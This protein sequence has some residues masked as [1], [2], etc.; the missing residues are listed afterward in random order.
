EQIAVRQRTMLRD[1]RQRRDADLVARALDRL[2]ETARGLGNLVE[3]LQQAVV[4]DA[5][6]GEMVER[7][8]TVFGRYR[9][10]DGFWKRGVGLHEA[11]GPLY[12]IGVAVRDL[13]QAEE[14]YRALGA[15]LHGRESVAGE[16]VEVSFVELGGVHIELLRPLD[17]EGSV[18]RFLRERGQGVHH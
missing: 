6:L 10:R 15:H 4:A 13:Q 3:A 9:P 1:L 12:H 11:L 2:E 5:T 17:D 8:T 14:A 7:L 18:A 16:G